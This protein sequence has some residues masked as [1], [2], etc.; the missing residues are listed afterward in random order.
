V[1]RV[2]PAEAAIDKEFD[3]LIPEAAAVEGG[4]MVRI[5]LGGR[6]VA[7]WVLDI[8]TLDAGS[9]DS[10]PLDAG[11]LST[12]S[13]RAGEAGGERAL[14]A[15]ALVSGWG[16]EPEVV[17]L[18]G[19]AA[20][21]WAGRRASLLATASP[22]RRVP[23]L[24]APAR[25]PPAA[26]ATG[27]IPDELLAALAETRIDAEGAG[28]GGEGE[29]EGSGWPWVLRLPPSA[30]PTAVV[31]WLAQ[32]GPTLVVVSAL[33]RA[34]VLADR[35][36]RAGA[37]VALLP[38]EWAQARAGAAV[39]IGSRAAAWGPCPG[40]AAV[41]VVDGH[42]AALVQEQ[43]PTW[44][45]VDV[46]AERARRAGVPC[47]VISSCPPVELLAGSRLL[48]VP[49]DAERAGWSVIDV[50]DRRSDDPRLGLYS[51]AVVDAVRSEGVVLCVLNRVGRAR[52]LVCAT[53]ATIADCERCGAAV[54]SLQPD[55][56]SCPRCGLTR[57]IVCRNCTS[58]RLRQL[59]IGVSRAREELEALASRPVGEVTSAGEVQGDAEVIVGTEAVLHRRNRADAVAFLDFDQHLLGAR[60]RAPEEA[61]AL[62]ARASRLTGGRRPRRERGPGRVLVQTRLPDHPV[63]VAAGVADPG[64]LADH[65]LAIR[66]QL[67]LPPVNAVAAVSGPGAADLVAAV[68]ARP[69][70]AVPLEVLGPDQDRWLLRAADHTA[71]ADALAGLPRP[72][73]RVRIDVDPQRL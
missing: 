62:L 71:M 69:E 73:A 10:G 70:P 52:L 20:W 18:A 61:F 33:D 50:I 8:R 68:A 38:G 40:L 34:A 5:D 13:L 48:R 27:L 59:R 7:G 45:A 42:D 41:V 72:A 24:P 1:A 4:T 22:E 36:R 44:S 23:A 15:L 57:P 60:L 49:P 58:T 66:R 12:G 65:E 55:E 63:L 14:R 2:L 53:C 43:A 64:R 30:D 9:L 31:A 11:S 46:V 51:R 6:R 67:R 17:T 32:R 25:R 54:A 35:L 21:R 47:V 19:W 56:L 3:Y 28:G 16:P 26:P 29:A 39:V 37:E